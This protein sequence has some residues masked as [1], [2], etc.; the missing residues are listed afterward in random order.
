M[1]GGAFKYR[2]D[3]GC[4][5]QIAGV[6]EQLRADV[7]KL[8]RDLETNVIGPSLDIRPELSTPKGR[9]KAPEGERQE[10]T[11][12]PEPSLRKLSTRQRRAAK[13]QAALE[14]KARRNRVV[15]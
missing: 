11:S 14:A 9:R 4:L 5:D 8:T 2:Y 10:L 1:E 3:G 12:Q 13:V 6:I 7:F 15:K